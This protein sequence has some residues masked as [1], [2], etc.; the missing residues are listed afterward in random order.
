LS[1]LY[2]AALQGLAHFTDG[3]TDVKEVRSMFWI[4]SDIIS[5]LRGG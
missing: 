4:L 5:V 1:L 3:E 2:P